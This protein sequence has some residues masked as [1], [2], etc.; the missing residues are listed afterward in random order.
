LSSELLAEVL[1]LGHFVRRAICWDTGDGGGTLQRAARAKVGR[2]LFYRLDRA[3]EGE[4]VELSRAV[5][6]QQARR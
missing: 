4:V 3:G 1:E 2:A 6:E 5:T